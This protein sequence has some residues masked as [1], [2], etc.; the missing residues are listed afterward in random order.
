MCAPVAA[1]RRRRRIGALA[2]CQCCRRQVTRW[3]WFGA[4]CDEC[5][6]ALREDA[7][8]AR[9]TTPADPSGDDGEAGRAF[10]GET[11]DAEDKGSR[12][13]SLH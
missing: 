7:H 13:Q 3:R 9:R 8:E 11:G 1:G 6:E 2:L 4:V 12:A 10:T 5:S